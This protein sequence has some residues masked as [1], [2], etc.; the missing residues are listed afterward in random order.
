MKKHYLPDFGYKEQIEFHDEEKPQGWKFF[1]DL[2]SKYRQREKISNTI[3]NLKQEKQEHLYNKPMISE[4][5]MNK[6]VQTVE[7]KNTPKD[8]WLLWHH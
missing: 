5:N 6:K 8:N 2:I 3:S 4:M 1:L 7:I